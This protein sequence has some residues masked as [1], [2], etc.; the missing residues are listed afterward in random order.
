MSAF[1]D[2]LVDM[3]PLSSE[4]QKPDNPFRVV[5]DRTVGA[6]MEEDANLFEQLFL[7]TATGGWL[8]AHGRDYGV[9]RRLDESDESYRERIVFEKLEWLTASNLMN[10]YGLDLYAYVEDYNPKSNT[11]TSDNPYSSSRYMVYAD[12][13]LQATLNRKFIL[14]NGVDFL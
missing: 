8:D 5:L 1:V 12:S 3:L 9:S 11:L 13:D 14:D 6:L 4:L 2:M 7:Q 10:I